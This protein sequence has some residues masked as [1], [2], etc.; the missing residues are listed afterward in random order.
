M[1]YWISV[2]QP[3]WFTFSAGTGS[4]CRRCLPSSYPESIWFLAGR[5]RLQTSIGNR[6]GLRSPWKEFP[7]NPLR[8]EPHQVLKGE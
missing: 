6:R 2:L 8:G 5:L 3:C 7:R 1:T 4:S